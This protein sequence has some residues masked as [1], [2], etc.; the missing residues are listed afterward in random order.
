MIYYL[1]K[2]EYEL[3]QREIN[4]I[5]HTQMIQD[6]LYGPLLGFLRSIRLQKDGNIFYQEKNTAQ[7]KKALQ[8]ELS[9]FTLELSGTYHD[10]TR[11]VGH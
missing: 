2:K 10:V 5:S 3:A 1:I 11:Y 6:T 9:L 8:K 4:N 7:K